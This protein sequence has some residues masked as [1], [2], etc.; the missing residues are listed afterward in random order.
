MNLPTP[1]NALHLKD[2]LR[3]L[4]DEHKGHGG[5]VLVIGGAN[6]MTGAPVLSGIAA[7]YSGAGWVEIAFLAEP[8]PLLI[9]EH[10]ELM[11]RSAKELNAL[12][13]S[14]IAIGPGLGQ[15]KDAYSLLRLAL[16]SSVPLVI[17]ADALNLL[18]SHSE[19]LKQLTERKFPSVL[20]P[21]PGEAA[22]LLNTTA[23][24][25]QRDRPLAIRQLVALTH[26]IVVLKGQGTLCLSPTESLHICQEGNSGMGSGGM[27]D[28]LTGIIA[29]LIAQGIKHHLNTWEATCLGVQ[30]HAQAAD[31]LVS[32]KGSGKAA[33]GPLGLTA[34]EVALEVRRL[35]N[36]AI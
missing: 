29:A 5:R 16:E 30:L 2:R 26:A 3:R 10:P 18:A 25:V 21:H 12:T 36:L 22:S 8:R 15:S 9:S 23:D 14:V 35:L 27:G 24:E 32:G 28:T 17:D 11:L 20:T 34:S 19:L 31:N 7:M 1:I 6:S 33:I 4:P 13:A